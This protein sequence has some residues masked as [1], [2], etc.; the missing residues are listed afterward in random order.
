MV[1]TFIVRRVC[2][3][4]PS[5][6]YE[7]TVNEQQLAEIFPWPNFPWDRVQSLVLALETD[8]YEIDRL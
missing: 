8:R 3:D 2:A 1:R 5:N 4:E 7:E 6:G